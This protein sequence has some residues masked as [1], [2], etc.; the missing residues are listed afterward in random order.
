MLDLKNTI[1][2]E[3]DWRSKKSIELA[4]IQKANLEND[5]YTQINSLGGQ[6]MSALIYAKKLELEHR[7]DE[8]LIA[9]YFNFSPMQGFADNDLLAPFFSQY[10]CQTC[11]NTK[12]GTRYYCSATIG[13]AHTNIREKL[14]VCE[15]CYLYFFS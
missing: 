11:G 10:A 4:E 3:V 5:G 2:I 9:N 15:D 6:T 8:K 1:K 7:P 13:K 14:E 12:A